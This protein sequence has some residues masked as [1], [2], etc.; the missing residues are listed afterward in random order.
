MDQILMGVAGGLLG[1]LYLSF[2]FAAFF[3]KG[4]LGSLLAAAILLFQGLTSSFGI[5]WLPNPSAVLAAW[6][7]DIEMEMTAPGVASIM[8]SMLCGVAVACFT[9]FTRFLGRRID[10]AG[11]A[12]AARFAGPSDP[13]GN[14]TNK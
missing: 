3:S 7:I 14:R 5:S 11:A 12:I 1:A 9:G 4:A 10:L 8:V 6:G 13:T 2:L